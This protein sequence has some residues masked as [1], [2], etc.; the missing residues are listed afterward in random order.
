MKF[1]SVLALGSGLVI[2]ALLL[3]ACKTRALA[4]LRRAESVDIPRFM[5][6]WY[7][8]ACIP[9]FIEKHEYN[10]VESYHQDAK[11]RIQTVFTFNKG[12][13][14]GPVRRMTPVG[15]VTEGTQG[16]V[17]GMR[18]VW[19][20]K[21]DY[22]IMYVDSDYSQTV[23]GRE[24]RDYAWIMARTPTMPDA[25]YGRL[26]SLLRS[27]GYDTTLLRKVPQQPRAKPEP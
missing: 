7:V 27:E 9:T 11:G 5:G 16:T 3:S 25:D 4:P 26:T 18:F 22:R 8:I 14:E 1:T 12:G 17:W 13:F 6:P 2:A 15:F 20:I 19:P 23:V 21:A 24:K 10:A